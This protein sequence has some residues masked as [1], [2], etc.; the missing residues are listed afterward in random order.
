MKYF[1]NV[2]SLLS[3]KRLGTVL[4]YLSSVF[5]SDKRALSFECSKVL[6]LKWNKTGCLYLLFTNNNLFNR[7]RTSRRLIIRNNGQEIQ[8]VTRNLNAIRLRQPSVFESVCK[9]DIKGTVTRPSLYNQRENSIY[10]KTQ[11]Q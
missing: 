7:R 2:H 3:N 10:A 8:E 11:F 1:K 9:P 6:A 4:E 5:N